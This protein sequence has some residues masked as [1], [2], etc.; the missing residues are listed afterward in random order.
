MRPFVITL[1]SLCAGLSSAAAGAAER[2]NVIF[3]LADDKYECP[4]RNAAICREN[5]CFS[6]KLVDPQMSLN[7]G[8]FSANAEN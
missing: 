5:A 7:C 8:R 2:P 3:I 1:I 4:T 6:S